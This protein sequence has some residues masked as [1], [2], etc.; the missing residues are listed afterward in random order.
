M[1][2]P[3]KFVVVLYEMAYSSEEVFSI[4]ISIYYVGK[5][6]S[7]DHTNFENYINK[8]IKYEQVGT[9]KYV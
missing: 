8:L 5:L 1:L 2:C 3:G 7:K 4:S 6:L 9:Y